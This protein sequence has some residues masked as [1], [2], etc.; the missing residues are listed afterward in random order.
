[1]TLI[2]TVFSAVGE[3]IID[4]LYLEAGARPIEPVPGKDSHWRI[5]EDLAFG[6]TVHP[7]QRYYLAEG[8]EP[9]KPPWAERPGDA[10]G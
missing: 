10:G 8:W 3:G 1:M 2:V 5:V 7:T 4:K 6:A 9:R